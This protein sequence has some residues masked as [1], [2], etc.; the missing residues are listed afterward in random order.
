MGLLHELA[1]VQG[2]EHMFAS[3]ACFGFVLPSLSCYV[4]ER[5]LFRSREH[6]GHSS[7][8]GKKSFFC[9]EYIEI[10]EIPCEQGSMF[11]LIS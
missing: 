3:D 1:Y 7:D 9:T 10:S 4:L 5:K 2:M 6:C 8:A 11:D